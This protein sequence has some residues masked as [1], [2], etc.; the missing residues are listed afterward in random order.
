MRRSSG[1]RGAVGI[2]C[3]VWLVVLIFVGYCLVQIVPVKIRASKFQDFM[4]EEAGFGSIKNLEQLEKEILEVLDRTEPR[5][6]LHEIL[7]L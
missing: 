3:V 5:F 1:Q 6:F 4:E 2:G 7:E